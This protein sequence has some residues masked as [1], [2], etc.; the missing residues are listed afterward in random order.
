MHAAPIALALSLCSSSVDP[1]GDEA[2]PVGA[3]APA[4]AWVTHGGSP[5][6]SRAS[7]TEPVRDQPQLAWSVGAEGTIEGDPLV[8]GNRV[9][10][11]VSSSE[12]RALHLLD[13]RDG[14]TTARVAFPKA[15]GPLW[16][17][18]WRNDL[19]VVVGSTI[20]AYRLGAKGLIEV[21]SYTADQALGPPLLFEDELYVVAGSTL[22]RL[23][24]GRDEP[25]WSTAGEWR[26]R[27]S[28]YGEELWV[29]EVPTGG[30]GLRRVSRE[31]GAPGTRH[32]VMAMP[33]ELTAPPPGRAFAAVMGREFLLYLDPPLEMQP[34]ASASCIGQAK[35]RTSPG[36]TWPVSHLFHRSEAA[37]VEGEWMTL[38]EPPGDA[39][40][41]MRSA[42][43]GVLPLATPQTHPVLTASEGPPARARDVVYLAGVAL[44]LTSHRLL[45]RLPGEVQ[46]P[47][48]PARDT[49][50]VQRGERLLEAWR[51]RRLVEASGLTTGGLADDAEALGEARAVLQDGT[52]QAGAFELAQRG[53]EPVLRFV[54]RA[55]SSRNLTRREQTPLDQV[56]LV[57]DA[58]DRILHTSGPVALLRGA[59]ALIG[60][61]L[62][63]DYADLA[64]EALQSKDYLL[65]GRLVER[66][67]AAGASETSLKRPLAQ[68]ER[69]ASKGSSERR[70]E[71]AAEVEA[72]LA[73]LDG[74]PAER[75]C[76]LAEALPADEH[77]LRYHLLRRVLAGDP[78]HD[79]AW[80]FLSQLA[81]GHRLRLLAEVA[82]EHP[83][84]ARLADQVRSLLPE[85]LD[86]GDGPFQT[87]EWVE[88]LIALERSEV[89][90]LE[91][92][93][94]ATD[95]SHDERKLGSASLNWRPDLRGFQSEQLFVISPVTRPG[96]IARCLSLGELVCEALDGIFAGG[97]HRRDERYRL[98]I[99]LFESKKEYL[100]QS[101][102]GGGGHAGLAWTAG[103]FSP[104]E[105]V[106]R[107]FLP[108]GDEGFAD[109]R[110]TFV[111]ELTHQWIHNRCPLFT[112]AESVLRYQKPPTHGHWVVEGFA[113]LIEEFR[114]D[115][116]T[117]TWTPENSTS[118]RRDLVAN[119]EPDQLLPWDKVLAGTYRDF[120]KLS[121]RGKHPIPMRTHL[122]RVS[123]A[124]EKTLYYAQ[125]QAVCYYLFQAEDGALRDRLLAYIGAYYSGDEAAMEI[126]RALGRSPQEIGEAAV[127]FAKE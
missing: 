69:H 49:V 84:D 53:D 28:L 31:S 99:H 101:S 92:R 111:H 88:F 14:S 6:R 122:G 61:E 109:V 119:A 58:A 44:D 25:V 116:E 104:L 117:W 118:R 97:V 95:L 73:I 106:S 35:S 24:I 32:V 65:V 7:S 60:A 20:E 13:L 12:G 102:K 87:A 120:S 22:L 83:A 80:G 11:A 30:M 59:D 40:M 45:W 54:R 108:S 94:A 3:E 71:R 98:Q 34:G 55:G 121:N 19:V 5:A 123:K 39:R 50:L 21:W 91:P 38:I 124:T 37:Q 47:M 93:P 8:W 2:L 16:P 62:A 103:H 67:R 15:E 82:E 112:N 27:P 77:D 56:A 75:L 1:A 105:N 127:R 70:E 52:I 46:G 89:R 76:A 51:A 125:A 18:L 100:A 33:G 86:P 110:L 113:S 114:F 66:A 64:I 10:L 78:T 17:A 29:P 107:L 42:E 72:R 96:A 115:T 36:E 9:F 57:L 81:M 48:I 68:L 90:I 79:R 41:W 23:E 126:E 43:K 85:G 74:I 63:E 26:G 4:G